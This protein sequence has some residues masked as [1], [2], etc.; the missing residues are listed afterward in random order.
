MSQPYSVVRVTYSASNTQSKKILKKDSDKSENYE[1][2]F[3]KICRKIPSV[4]LGCHLRE[5]I[6][7]RELATCCVTV[8]REWT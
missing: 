8:I 4:Y 1:G 3:S 7:M 6:M 2:L 5:D